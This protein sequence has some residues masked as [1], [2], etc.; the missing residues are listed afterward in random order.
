MF[1]QISKEEFDR[2]KVNYN[3]SYCSM[4]SDPPNIFYFNEGEPYYTGLR[5]QREDIYFGRV[6][7]ACYEKYVKEK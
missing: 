6:F 5:M 2:L 1:I 7:P 4:I 3:K